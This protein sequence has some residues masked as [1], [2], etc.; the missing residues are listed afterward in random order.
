MKKIT[1][2]ENQKEIAIKKM[3]TTPYSLVNDSIGYRA[4]Y[5]RALQDLGILDNISAVRMM[6]EVENMDWQ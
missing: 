5:I 6:M 4:G 1:V 2:N 3:E